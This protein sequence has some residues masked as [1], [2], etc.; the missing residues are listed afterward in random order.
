MRHWKL[1]VAYVA[2]IGVGI[3]WAGQVPNPINADNTITAGD[4]L[5]GNGA[6]RATDSGWSLV[7]MSRGG[8][9]AALTAAANNLLYSTTSGC[10]L[11]PTANSSIL[12][13]NGSGTP[14]WTTSLPGGI[15]VPA[16]D[17]P[18]PTSATLGGLEAQTCATHQ[19]LDIIPTTQVQPSCAQPAFS[20]LSGLIAASQL[21]APT[22]SAFG[23]IY[24]ITC[25]SHQWIDVVP[26]SGAQPT[27]A[28][29]GITDVSGVSASSPLSYSAGTFALNYSTGLSTSGGNLVLATPTATTIGG[30]ESVTCASHNWIDQVTTAGVHVCA[31]P[32]FSDISGTLPLTQLATQAADTVVMNASGASAAPTATSLASLGGTNSC[33]GASNAMTYN[34]STHAW[35]CNTISGG[36]GSSANPS[37]QVGTSAVN[38]VAATYMTSDS[39]P[40]INQAMSPTWT[41]THQFNVP[42]LVTAGAAQTSATLRPEG[43]VY[44]ITATQSTGTG[45]GEQTLASYSLPANSLDIAGRNIRIVALFKHAANSDTVTNKL[46][47][48][49][50]VMTDAGGAASNQVTI[51][52]CYILKTGTNTQNVSFLAQRGTVAVSPTEFAATETDSSAIT[53]KATATDGTSSAGD[54]NLVGFFVEYLN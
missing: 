20:D 24:A 47:F 51:V 22:I 3:A 9:N 1:A 27:C 37:A 48:G 44:S 49:S 7:P 21:I 6:Q 25:P 16:A 28:Q 10:A 8:C 2:V 29:P 13:T 30:V 15:S 26:T 36:T 53:I 14:I 33:A 34:S 32:A 19:W 11:L 45:T 39:A 43:V 50:E 42:P 12:A 46:Y 54:G 40:P 31:Q 17:L 4:F 52:T 41:G 38:G 35:G 23:G 18:L 5:L